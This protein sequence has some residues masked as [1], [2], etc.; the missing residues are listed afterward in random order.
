MLSPRIGRLMADPSPAAVDRFWT[1]TTAAGT[2]LI[3]P[4]DG[5]SVLVTF[6][7]RGEARSTRAWWNFDVPLARLPG[8]DLWHG[9]AV[10]PADLRTIYC[11]LHDDA[12]TLPA[13]ASGAGPTHIDAANPHRIHFPADPQ[14]PDDQSTW[15]SVLTLPDAPGEPWT[16]PRHDVPPGSLTAASITSTA[17][18]GSHPVTV[19]QPAGVPAHHAP[20]LVVFDGYLAQTI[21]RIPTVLDNLIH[22]GKIP[23]TAALFVHTFTQRRNR[24]LTPAPALA[25]FV[26]G[27]L[28]PWARARW[29][30]GSPDGADLIAGVSRGGLAAAYVGLSRPESFAGVIAQSGSFWWPP[31]TEGQPCWLIDHIDRYPSPGARFYL[32]VGTQETIP[33][34]DGAPSQVTACRAMRD[35]L[36][37][38][39]H[40]VTYAEYTGGHDY[41]N[42]RRTIAEGLLATHAGPR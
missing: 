30:I 7:W 5:T 3:E 39:G 1:A 6:L 22:A 24:D 33:G 19:Y 23:P 14:D 40:Q 41:L 31:P 10:F 29:S 9:S 35:A 42:W 27:E 15:A 34:P 38:Q 28:L 17:L 11:L 36:R 26:T 25:D 2:P 20:V 32:D 4:L 37:H 8:T 13:D 16:A 21:L 12:E 18:G